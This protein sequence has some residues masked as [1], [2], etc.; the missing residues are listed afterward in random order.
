MTNRPRKP[1]FERLKQSL[2]EGLAH[3]RDELT[4]K[5]VEVPDDPPVIDART[6]AA[7]RAQAAMSQRVFAKLLSVSHKTLQSWEQ[8]TRSP[9]DASLRLIQVFSEHPEIVCQSVGLPVVTLTGVSIQTAGKG[10]R[11]IVVNQQ[12]LPARKAVTVK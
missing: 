2:E 9:S 12:R 1:L 11:R 7:L 3:S 10:R 5:T 4:L 6:L 8:G